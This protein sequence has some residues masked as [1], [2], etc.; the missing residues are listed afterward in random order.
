MYLAYLLKCIFTL[1]T[2]MLT[3]LPSMFTSIAQRNF[4]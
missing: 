4:Y 2:Y 3:F 1:L